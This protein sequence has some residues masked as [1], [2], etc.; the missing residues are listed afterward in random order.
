MRRWFPCRALSQRRSRG[1]RSGTKPGMA[2]RPCERRFL[3][4]TGSDPDGARVPQ[5][6]PGAGGADA[7]K[8]FSDTP[9]GMVARPAKRRAAV[10]GG[11][12]GRSSRPARIGQWPTGASLD[13]LLL[14][15][16]PR[17]VRPLR[18]WGAFLSNQRWSK[19]L[20]LPPAP[21]LRRGRLSP[22]AAGARGEVGQARGE[23]G[24]R[25]RRARRY[26]RG[27]VRSQAA[28]MSRA[29]PA[30]LR[31]RRPSSASESRES[32][33]YMAIAA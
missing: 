7:V 20:P 27:S 1:L 10:G 2:H 18:G 6:T 11:R 23:G 31:P 9:R 12:A 14:L 26:L 15:P 21:G 25:E 19:L 16:S 5:G 13:V 4:S 30:R 8:S 3:G 32:F 24:R 33:S 17:A 29:R 28:R 22:R